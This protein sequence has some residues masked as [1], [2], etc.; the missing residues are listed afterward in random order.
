MWKGSTW[1]CE[2]NAQLCSPSMPCFLTLVLIVTACYIQVYSYLLFCLYFESYAFP[3]II[4]A[5]GCPPPHTHTLVTWQ[6][7][8]AILSLF[9][10][11]PSPSKFPKAMFLME[12]V[13]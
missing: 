1:L 10:I 11:C 8:N 13:F 7:L 3:I 5:H 12:V 2:R 6:I 9:L 4:G